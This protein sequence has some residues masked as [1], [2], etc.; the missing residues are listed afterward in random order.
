MYKIEK[1]VIDGHRVKLCNSI[2][3]HPYV[4]DSLIQVLENCRQQ[5]IRIHVEQDQANGPWTDGYLHATNGGS[6]ILIRNFKGMAYCKLDPLHITA[7]CHSNKKCGG[8]LWN[9][10]TPYKNRYWSTE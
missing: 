8:E 2:Q 6:L 10:M 9:K 3:Y 5:K 7:V 1:T 4:A